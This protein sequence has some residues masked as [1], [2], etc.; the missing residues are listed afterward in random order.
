MQSTFTSLTAAVIAPA[1][2][3]RST[4]T[5]FNEG[6]GA[7]HV[8]LG[9]RTTVSTTNYTNRIASGAFWQVPDGFIGPV[10]GIFAAAGTARVSEVGET[11]H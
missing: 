7:L 1:N 4:L 2:V 5:I 11:D 3:Y 6:S 8:L 9:S 10:Q